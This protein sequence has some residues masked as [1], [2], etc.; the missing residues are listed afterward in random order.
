MASARDL[1]QFWVYAWPLLRTW[2]ISL[3]W[4]PGKGKE[5]V[6]P[7]QKPTRDWGLLS[8]VGQQPLW[9]AVCQSN[10]LT[11]W[12]PVLDPEDLGENSGSQGS[13]A[14]AY[15]SDLLWLFEDTVCGKKNQPS[16]ISS[17]YCLPPRH[18]GEKQPCD[19]VGRHRSRGWIKQHRQLQSLFQAKQRRVTGR[20]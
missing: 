8:E 3:A 14:G 16:H 20:A 18:C 17:I 13:K 9:T 4:G 2:I 19:E 1:S 11:P 6:L 12:V 15:C 7:S 10:R 5:T